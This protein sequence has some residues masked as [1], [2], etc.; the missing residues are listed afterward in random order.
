ML[1][2]MFVEE[3]ETNAATFN[4]RISPE[5][6]AQIAV[7]SGVAAFRANS[8]L[9]QGKKKVSK[10]NVICDWASAKLKIMSVNPAYFKRQY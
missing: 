5:L 8:A 2:D 9:W 7:V 10:A 1:R 4:G 3:D 6:S